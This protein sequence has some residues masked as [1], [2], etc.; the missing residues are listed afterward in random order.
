MYS[1][2]LYIVYY[3]M[4][5]CSRAALY[6]NY[7]YVHI[8]HRVSRYLLVLT[9]SR[10]VFHGKPRHRVPISLHHIVDET[11]T[12]PIARGGT[13]GTSENQNT[14]SHY[15]TKCSPEISYSLIKWTGSCRREGGCLKS[16]VVAE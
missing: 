8:V 1:A 7:I 10:R 3:V 14:A 16:H 6:L 13:G 9:Y 2:K 12:R 11:A 15:A 5:D 4:L